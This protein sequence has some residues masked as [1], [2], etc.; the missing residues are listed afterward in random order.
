[1]VVSDVGIRPGEGVRGCAVVHSTATSCK[2]ARK[3]LVGRQHLSQGEEV[4]RTRA[5]GRR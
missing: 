4:G 1:M 3:V 5:R 2:Q